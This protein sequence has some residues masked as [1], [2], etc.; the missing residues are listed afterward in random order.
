MESSAFNTSLF[1]RLD[2]KQS[3]SDFKSGSEYEDGFETHFTGK[4]QRPRK[5]NGV[6][7][8]DMVSYVDSNSFYQAKE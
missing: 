4:T 8:S 6:H 3:G 1:S 5:K 7:S 2:K